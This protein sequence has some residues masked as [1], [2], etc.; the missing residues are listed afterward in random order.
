MPEIKTD[1][2]LSFASEGQVLITSL[3]SFES[4]HSALPNYV[5]PEIKIDCFRS[6]II[7]KHL[8]P[9]RE[10][11]FETFRIGEITFKV[12]K[13]C[14][15]CRETT[16]NPNTLKFEE[17]AEPLNTLRK[18]HGDGVKGYFGILARAKCTGSV[19]VGD[20]VIM[21]AIQQENEPGNLNC[22]MC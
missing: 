20:K 22:K 19:K 10:D 18:H 21:R 11:F 1:C 14:D 7:L 12:I 17:N 3:G 8:P 9:Y 4:L 16:I 6:N 13:K 5:K 15:R 2:N